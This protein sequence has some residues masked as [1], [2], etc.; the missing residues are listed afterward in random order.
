MPVKARASGNY[1]SLCTLFTYNMCRN[2]V[3]VIV[4]TFLYGFVR[5]SF[6]YVSGFYLLLFTFLCCHLMAVIF[7]C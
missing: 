1:A 6:A 5:F 4:V 2:Y 7:L 3:R